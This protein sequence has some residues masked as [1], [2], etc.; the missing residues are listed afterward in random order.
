M[1][2]AV[3]LKNAITSF[4]IPTVFLTAWTLLLFEVTPW[5]FGKL[6]RWLNNTY[7]PNEIVVTENGFLIKLEHW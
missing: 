6:L 5:G 3:V 7:H 1:S 2:L 4:I